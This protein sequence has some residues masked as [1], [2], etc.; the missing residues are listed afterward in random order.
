L[1]WEDLRHQRIEEMVLGG[2]N[3]LSNANKCEIEQL[4]AN[5]ELPHTR[6]RQQQLQWF[7]VRT[8]NNLCDR[9]ESKFRA[10]LCDP[11][12]QKQPHVVSIAD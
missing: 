7:P 10:D 12:C 3:A 8:A 1:V 5:K 6:Y 11:E 4:L 9:D 2:E